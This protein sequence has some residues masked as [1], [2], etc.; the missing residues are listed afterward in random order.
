MRMIAELRDA[1]SLPDV[2]A[3]RYKSEAVRFLV[4]LTIVLGVMGYP[5][6]LYRYVK[7]EL[8]H[9]SPRRLAKPVAQLLT[10]RHHN[11]TILHGTTQF[12][13]VPSIVLL[14]CLVR[15]LSADDPGSDLLT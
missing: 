12:V 11:L 5:H 3:A 1:I 8:N 14:E 13:E 4:A 10:S 9:Y 2:V 6:I 7:H 15:F